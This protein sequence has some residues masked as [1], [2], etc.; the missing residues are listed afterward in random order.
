MQDY[1]TQDDLTSLGVDPATTDIDKLVGELNDKVE[2]KIGDEIVESLTEPDVQTLVDMQ[3]TAS[4]EELGKWIAEHVPDYQEIVQDNID[5]VLG[6]FA[7][8]LPELEA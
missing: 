3:E 1:I 5:I 2:E 7:E 8:T 4:D 6:E